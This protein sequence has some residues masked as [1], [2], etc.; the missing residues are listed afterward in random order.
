[1][2]RSPREFRVYAR[3]ASA[4][5]QGFRSSGFPTRHAAQPPG[6]HIPTF[7]QGIVFPATGLSGCAA[8]GLEN[9]TDEVRPCRFFRGAA[10]L[11]HLLRPPT[12]GAFMKAKLLE[13]G[14]ADG[15]VREILLSEEEFL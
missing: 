9:P 4:G 11:H 7:R 14:A 15:R 2:E 10:I 1:M 13:V 3:P 5:G 6:D 12:H 8:V